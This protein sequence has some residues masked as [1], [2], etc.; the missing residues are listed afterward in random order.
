MLYEGTFKI[1]KRSLGLLSRRERSRIGIVVLLQIAF[2][3][4]DLIAVAIVGILGSLAITG[5][6][7][8][9]PGNRVSAALDFL[10]IEDLT[11]QKQVAILGIIAATLMT[12][13]TIFTVIFSRKTVFFLSRR[14]A[15]ISSR[16]VA[17]VLS[18]SLIQLQRKSMQQSLYAV[19]NGVDV[20][21]MG[22]LNTSTSMIS[23]VSLLLIL[24]MGLF[25]VDPT[26]AI[27]TF[28]VFAIV[29]F[30][31]YKLMEVRARE[32]GVEQ[33]N[34]GIKNNEKI[35]EVFSS[36]RE[37]VV[38][39][40][41]SFYV[42]EISDIRMRLAN[43]TAER[44]FMPY[45]SKYVIEV[46]L[47]VGALGIGALQFMTNDAPRAVA[48]L[49][50]FLA[51]STR[52]SPAI[53]RLQQGAISIRASV[54]SAGPTLDLIDQLDALEEVQKS[55]AKLS[56][57]HADFKPFVRL[58]DVS[59]SYPGAKNNAVKAAN[60]DIESG[61]IVAIVGPSGAGKTTLIDILLGVILP[62][63]GEITIGGE[64]PLGAITR[65]PGALGYVPQDIVIINGTVRENVAMGYPRI[66]ASDE[67]VWKALE[68]S[69]LKEFVEG[70]DKKLDSS[71]GDR[72]TKLSGGQRQRL[73]IARALFTR[74]RLLVLDEATSA[75]DGETEGN[76]SKA[77]NSLKG[78]VTVILI[79]HRLSTVKSADKVIYMQDGKI[80]ASGT[81]DE[82][83]NEIPNFDKQAKL[84]GL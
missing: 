23:D 79:A 9:K 28:I 26:V 39:D 24:A 35:L 47:I 14:S 65:W 67:L 46:T 66:S 4:L 42:G 68:N 74:P 8:R 80:M 55:N 31:L 3:I 52:I 56:L 48:V 37:V 76:I 58:K 15:A 71:V 29:A 16:L 5:V 57:E 43:L 13:K 53:L 45:I 21:A 6:G 63:S 32:I 20:I 70:L 51:A 73:G 2:G 62:D 64:R 41:R 81:F 72:G 49:T 17:K 82:V 12:L 10:G 22:I 44:T 18:Q 50:V 78:H 27:S 38:R 25:I 84:M 59:F 83:R 33:A 11:L 30:A 36:Y 19:T 34:L 61:Q 7:S 54:G 60:F 69:Q 1:L 75:L 77:I 40:R